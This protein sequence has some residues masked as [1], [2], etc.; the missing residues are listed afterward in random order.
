MFITH[1]IT[2]EIQRMLIVGFYIKRQIKTPFQ[3]RSDPY[4]KKYPHQALMR[5][6]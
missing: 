3:H 1:N 4:R 5:Y 2:D 6:F